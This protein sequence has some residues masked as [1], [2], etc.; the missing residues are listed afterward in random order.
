MREKQR[1][2]EGNRERER[3][4]ERQRDRET[5]RQTDRQRE[6][7]TERGFECSEP[8]HRASSCTA[9]VQRAVRLCQPWR[10]VQTVTAQRKRLF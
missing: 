4:R 8:A 10:P 3:E 6:R 7:E 5:D 1:Q 2:R 9:Q